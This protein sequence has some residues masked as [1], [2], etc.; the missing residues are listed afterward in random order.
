LRKVS[1]LIASIVL[2]SSVTACSTAAS[3]SETAAFE[4]IKAACAAFK[5]GSASK[6]IKYS[7]GADSKPVV[8]FPA[9]LNAKH[10][11]T[12]VLAEGNGPSF[13]GDE[14]INFDFQIMNGGTGALVQ[15]SSFNGTDAASQLITK[16][17]RFLCQPLS[18]VKQ[19]STVA[20]LL[21][22]TEFKDGSPTD[23][24]LGVNDSL[25]LVIKLN[26]VFLPHATGDTQSAQTGFP[27]V[28]SV[29]AGEPG[30]VLQDWDY[31]AFT[32]F[33]KSTLI[34]GKGLKVKKG[35]TV[36]LNY[37]G[38]VW[39]G[40]KS[41][42]DSS[43][44]NGHPATFPLVD[45]QLIPG[46]IKAI[47]GET[48]GSRVIAVIPAKDGYGSQASASIPANSTLIFVVDILGAE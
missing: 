28:V 45:G 17:T 21:P 27:Q 4:G 34:K 11:E 35:Q 14:V 5:T 19:G 16:A 3:N 42:F 33:A 39:S 26:K 40:A 1:A 24:G 12:V 41:K 43:W 6:Q 37:S 13:T 8:S 44:Q 2:A 10:A 46:F 7:L 18:G 47:Q 20:I 38:W 9:P 23:F 22:V 15:S 48:V 31:P 32:N 36:T 30:L 29:G 25:V